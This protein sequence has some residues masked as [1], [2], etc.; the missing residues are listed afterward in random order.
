MFY[1]PHLLCKMWEGG[2]VGANNVIKTHQHLLK[3]LRY[4]LRSERNSTGQ[5]GEE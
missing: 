5:I 2:K 3:G 4:N 1:A